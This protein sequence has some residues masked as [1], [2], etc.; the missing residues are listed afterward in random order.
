MLKGLKKETIKGNFMEGL[1]TQCM[2]YQRKQKRQK[3]LKIGNILVQ[4]S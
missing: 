3:T 1:N 4:R 2:K